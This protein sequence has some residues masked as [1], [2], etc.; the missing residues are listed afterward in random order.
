LNEQGCHEQKSN[1]IMV[2]IIIIDI[3]MKPSFKRVRGKKGNAIP[4]TGP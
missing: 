4:V 2:M 1:I 3:T